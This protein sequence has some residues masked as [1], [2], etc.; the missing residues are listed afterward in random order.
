[1]LNHGTGAG[2]CEQAAGRLPTIDGQTGGL[3][4]WR[5]TYWYWEALVF[6]AKFW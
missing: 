1:M 5:K 6:L 3:T 4:S 2:V